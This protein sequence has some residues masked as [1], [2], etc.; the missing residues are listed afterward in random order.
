M[1]FARSFCRALLLGVVVGTLSIVSAAHARS[2]T[3]E[4]FDTEIDNTIQAFA[5]PVFR[6]A[7]I[8]PGAVRLHLVRSEVPNAFVTAGRHMFITTGLL[9]A[10]EHAGQ[11]IGV[12]AHEAGHIAGGHLVRLDSMLRDTATPALLGTVLAA[13]LGA[14]AGSPDAAIAAVGAGTAAVNRRMLSF[15]RAQEQA[16]DRAAVSYLERSRQSARGLYEFLEYLDDQQALILS[17]GAQEALSYDI[18]H[19]LTRD[20]IAYLRNHVERSAYSDRP[21]PEAFRQM[22]ARMIAKL[23]GFIDAPARTLAKYDASDRG[24][25]ARYA[26]AI[27]L[28]Q[29]G[30][31]R[32][33]AARHSRADRRA[34]R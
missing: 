15:T 22:H 7:G 25:P 12:L 3:V 9:R 20:R 27:A 23:D 16:A 24:L 5:R 28:Y 1:P 17:R 8:E 6:A 31:N 29:G 30:R 11:V 33:R 2:R 26:R 21:V 34:P 14:L 4:I 19:P 13:A 10:A 32:A 18:T